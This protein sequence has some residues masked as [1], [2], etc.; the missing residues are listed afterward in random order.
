MLSLFLS[1]LLI[2]GKVVAARNYIG[3]NCI[4]GIVKAKIR[5]STHNQVPSKIVRYLLTY[6]ISECEPL[7]ILNLL[8]AGKQTKSHF[9]Q[10]FNVYQEAIFF[11]FEFHFYITK[12]ERMILFT[13]HILIQYYF[14]L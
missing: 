4:Q 14:I 7:F 13:L 10:I 9:Y 3:E 2:L 8:P 12:S 5:K 6:F 11:L 1:I